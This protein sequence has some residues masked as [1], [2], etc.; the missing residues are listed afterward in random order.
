MQS[1]VKLYPLYSLIHSQL[2]MESVKG[3]EWMNEPI[4]F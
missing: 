3:I 4:D 2:H 1:F